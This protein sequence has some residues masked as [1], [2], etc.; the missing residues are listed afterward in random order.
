[1]LWREDRE[2]GNE[3]LLGDVRLCLHD[4]K[5]AGVRTGDR[6]CTGEV[7]GFCTGEAA[8]V[9]GDSSSVNVTPTVRMELCM[10]AE[11]DVQ[12]EG[13]GKQSERC[14]CQAS[15]PRLESGA[16]QPRVWPT[17]TASGGYAASR[18]RNNTLSPTIERELIL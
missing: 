6:V 1:M 13:R 7:T 4:R 12:M 9:E 18:C 11:S 2:L 3:L 8:T 16:Q 17:D 15:K 5:R 14:A 10:S